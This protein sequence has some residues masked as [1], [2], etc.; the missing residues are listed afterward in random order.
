MPLIAIV[1]HAQAS[2]GAADYDQLSA[3]GREQ[4][5]VVGAELARRQLRD[6]AVVTG[7]LRRQQD[8][9]GLLAAAA[10]LAQSSQVDERWD[11]YDH[12]ALLRRYV[13]PERVALATSDSRRFQGLL[14]EA[15][16][17]WSDDAEDAGWAAF[18]REAATALEDLAAGLPKGTDAVVVTS[19]GVLAALAAGLIHAPPAT[20]VALNRVAVNCAITTVI[21]GSS[22]A[23]LLTFNDHAHFAG[24]RRALLTYR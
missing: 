22:G 17:A 21:V 1:R 2:F 5:E 7:R 3:V 20:A 10:G 6:P 8:T 13:D 19:G 15:L 11:E 18:A 16:T 24:E 14:D 9:A 4:A 12:F 23:T